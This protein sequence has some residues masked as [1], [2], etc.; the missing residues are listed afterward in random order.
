MTLGDAELGLPVTIIHVG[1]DRPFRRRLMELGLLPG[2]RVEVVRIAPLGD[3]IEL[4]TRGGF[5]SI[6]KK[7]ARLVAVTREPAS[8]SL[9]SPT[10]VAP[11]SSG[12]PASS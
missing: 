11:L 2:T 6:R 4:A 10:A 12:L 1:G 8:A 5:L 7:E 3:P 9:P